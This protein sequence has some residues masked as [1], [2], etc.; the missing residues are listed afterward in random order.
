M[1]GCKLQTNILRLTKDKDCVRN[2]SCPT[3]PFRISL[4]RKILPNISSIFESS[5]KISCFS[6]TIDIDQS[7]SVQQNPVFKHSAAT[8]EK[9][10]PKN[11][12]FDEP[13]WHASELQNTDHVP[14]QH[15]WAGAHQHHP[16]GFAF[17]LPSWT[18]KALSACERPERLL[19][20][21]LS[22]LR[23]DLLVL[24]E[25]MRPWA[26]MSFGFNNTMPKFLLSIMFAS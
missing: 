3:N 5:S 21:P 16:F 6:W 9:N 2:A 18:R 17:G 10:R 23:R 7:Y 4:L 13:A 14:K 8:R 1:T 12:E 24:W 26:K 11:G 19:R 25:L 22:R 15:H 20:L